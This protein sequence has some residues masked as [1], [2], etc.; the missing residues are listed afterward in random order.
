MPRTPGREPI[1]GDPIAR[2][3]LS[4]RELT[5]LIAAQRGGAPFVALRDPSVGL[6][7][8]VLPRDETVVTV[9]RDAHA[10][11]SIGWDMQV[12]ALH[13]ELQRRGGVWTV[14]DDGISR[15]GTFVDNE[16]V[17]GRHR[18]HD[19]A[20]I[21]FGRTIV[22]FS[23]AA[24]SSV[25]A[26]AAANEP[27]LPQ[28]TAAQRRVLVELCRPALT[29]EEPGTAASNETIANE[30]AV[31]VGAVKLQ[32]RDLFSRFGLG[33]LPSHEKRVQLVKLALQLG[34]VSRRDLQ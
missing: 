19:E 21:R 18:L 23:A 16:R 32:L 27:A 14:V 12:S 1:D 22:F 17:I 3:A 34:L 28:L 10:D 11:L 13:A 31:T 6:V 8:F 30:L 9:G 2:H 26:T 20:R 24:A 29:P 33:P 7:V 25:E 4:P 5:E 15:N